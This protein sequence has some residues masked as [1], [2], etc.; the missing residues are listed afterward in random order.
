G[1]AVGIAYGI[2]VGIAYGIAVG[3][4]FGIAYGIAVGI[5]FGIAAITGLLRLYYFPLQLFFILPKA[6]GKFYRYHPVAWDDLCS[7]PFPKL[8]ELLVSY[9]AVD[10]KAGNAE[11]E[12][13]ITEYPSQRS[14]ALRA[15]TI[16]LIRQTA[17]AVDLSNLDRYSA[18]LPEGKK[19]FL[20]QTQTL[21]QLVHEISQLQIRLD[22][23]QRPILRE[24]VARVLRTEIENFQHR[25]AGFYEPLASEFRKAS[26]QWLRLATEQLQL[27]ESI[28]LKEPNPQI[29]RAGDLLNIEQEAFVPRYNIFSEIEQQIMLSTGCPGLVLY[30]R[31]RMGKS[32]ILNSLYRFLPGNVIPTVLSM[33]NPEA[34]TSLSDF[35][36][37]IHSKLQ[38][39][40]PELKTAGN[41]PGNL[42]AF[43]R[44]LSDCDSVLQEQNKRLLLALD[45]YENMDMKIGAEIFPED[46]LATLRESIQTHRC[47]TWIFTG[48]HEITELSH[49]PWTSYLVS[50]RTIEVP[51]FT[52]EETRLL[53]T[54][55][56]KYSS[57]WQKDAGNRPTFDPEFWGE[58]GIQRIH[59]QA[60]GWPY[61]VQLI[62]ETIIDLINDEEKQQVDGELFERALDRAIV[63][64]HTM[65]YELMHRESHFPGEWEYLSAFRA[66]E[67]QAPP[68]DETV[69]LSLRRRLL[70]VEENG[71]WSLRVPLMARWLKKRG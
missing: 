33:Q 2:A 62:A 42:A 30:G 55:P 65:L 7:V 31:R 27:A 69:N 15:K 17:A 4:A 36:Q 35:I 48:S 58:G 24:P 6:K 13:L 44:L 5:A 14:A 64:G 16:L 41:S 11:I 21:H 59:G 26:K 20:S 23:I 61:L 70:V 32:T 60:G 57:L 18:Q 34:F 38:I 71:E 10:P 52:A 49:A 9:A 53:L 54:E 22:T 50:A 37:S 29:F 43:Y 56:M 45:E 40:L 28:V 19:G 1:I 3:I 63:R 8:A 46:L 25:I 68:D 12:R 51:I 66:Q 39:A 47:I 67:K